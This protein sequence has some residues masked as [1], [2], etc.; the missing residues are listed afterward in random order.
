MT[1]DFKSLLE[2][3]LKKGDGFYTGDDVT[4]RSSKGLERNFGYIPLQGENISSFPDQGA[5]KIDFS[6][7]MGIS[8]SS[9]HFEPKEYHVFHGTSTDALDMILD[10]G[11]LRPAIELDK[12][13]K[14]VFGERKTERERERERALRQDRYGSS[15]S[16]HFGESGHCNN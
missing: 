12:M 5:P 15:S 6:Q 9:D 13:G 1:S 16:S 11:C 10:D 2:A 4:H 8:F 7:F 3:L 14:L